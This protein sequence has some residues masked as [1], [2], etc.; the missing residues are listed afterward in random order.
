MEGGEHL[1]IHPIETFAAASMVK[2]D[3]TFTS[4]CNILVDEDDE[5]EEDD[6]SE[7]PDSDHYDDVMPMT[8]AR[9]NRGLLFVSD[10]E[11]L[12]EEST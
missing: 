9:S 5:D 4:S 11:V 6:F 2:R 3:E 7:R 1:R 12:Q 8:T 10:Q